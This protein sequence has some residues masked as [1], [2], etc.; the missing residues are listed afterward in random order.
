[1][2]TRRSPRNQERLWRLL[3]GQPAPTA[4]RVSRRKPAPA[5]EPVEAPAPAPPTGEPASFSEAMA[6]LRALHHR[7]LW[8][9]GGPCDC[10]PFDLRKA[11]AALLARYNILL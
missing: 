9:Q 3:G 7:D 10:A 5:P 11:S 4:R 8:H 2:R 1:M 6:A